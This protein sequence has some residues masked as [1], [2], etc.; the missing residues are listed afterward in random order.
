M[1][2]R[3]LAPLALVTVL[4]GCAS[5]SLG[6]DAPADAR[7]AAARVDFNSMIATLNGYM[8]QPWCTDEAVVACADRSV[9]ERAFHIARGIDGALDAVGASLRAGETGEA[10]T[11]LEAAVMSLRALRAILVQHMG[12]ES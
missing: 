9:A 2:A 7:Y 6:T 3:I 4:T 10:D 8:A 11:Q 12:E 5:I 1:I